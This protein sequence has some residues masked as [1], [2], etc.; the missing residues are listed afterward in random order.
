MICDFKKTI[1][2]HNMISCG[3]TVIVGL[4]GG[5]DSMTLLH[6][7]NA[8]KDDYSLKIIA[9]H[10]NHCLRGDEADRDMNFCKK[11]CNELGIEI[12]FPQRTIHIEKDI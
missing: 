11:V 9:A 3:D 8:I 2:K 12:P 4:S 7:L 5:A 6:M 10:V 1:E